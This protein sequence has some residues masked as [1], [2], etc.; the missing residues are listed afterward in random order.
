[1]QNKFFYNLPQQKIALYPLPERDKSKL[2]VYNGSITDTFFEHLPSFLPENSIIIRNNSKVVKA[3][4]LAH[5]TSGKVFELFFVRL[6]ETTRDS[7]IVACLIKKIKKL[8]IGDE[9][10]KQTQWNGKTIQLKINYIERNED[11]AF[12]KFLWNDDNLDFYGVL[13]VFGTTPLPPYIKRPTEQSDDDRYQTLYAHQ[14]G[15]VAA[16]TAGLHFTER[17]DK[18]L[19]KKNIRCEHITLHVGPG[20]FQPLSSHDILKHK[21]HAEYFSIHKHVIEALLNASYVTLVGTTTLRTIESA[22]IL[23]HFP[24]QFFRL[25]N[26]EIEQWSHLKIQKFLTTKQAWQVLLEFMEKHNTD[27]ITGNTSLMITDEYICRTPHYLITNFHQPESTLLL[28]VASLIGDQWRMVYEHALQNDYRFLSYGDACLFKNLRL[29]A[30]Q[31][32]Q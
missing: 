18:M 20:T 4:I 28:I 15:S 5:N 8:K 2:L 14:P 17:V 9:L 7:A 30:L 11:I 22:Y 10:H 24:D 32:N 27:C 31:E 6:I 19:K 16:P 26:V 12:C 21:M 25:N 13:N 29:F 23:A 1:M 3:R